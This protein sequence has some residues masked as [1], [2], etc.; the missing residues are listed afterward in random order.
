M[1]N[2]RVPEG[3]RR[4]VREETGQVLF[5]GTE[6]VPLIWYKTVEQAIR[7]EGR[8]VDIWLASDVQ[9]E[10]RTIKE[11]PSGQIS[12]E[13]ARKSSV[14]AREGERLPCLPEYFAPNGWDFWDRPWVYV[15]V[16]NGQPNVGV[17]T[18]R[19][20]SEV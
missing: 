5:Q 20:V 13:Y 12:G 19:Q 8:E 7:Q 6:A 15:D 16:P 14:P 11:W 1:G 2:G 10:R 9:Q 3:A 17:T 18:N 4:T